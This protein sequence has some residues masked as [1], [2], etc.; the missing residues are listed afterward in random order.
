[1][2]GQGVIK[3]WGKGYSSAGAGGNQVLGQGVFKC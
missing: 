2:L 1:M 3:C